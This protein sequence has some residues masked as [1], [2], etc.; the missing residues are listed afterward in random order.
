[1]IFPAL[2]S[3]PIAYGFSLIPSNILVGRIETLFWIGFST[4]ITILISALLLIP[5][6]QLKQVVNFRFFIKTTS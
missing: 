4:I 3:L 5:L 6:D 2:I 1:M